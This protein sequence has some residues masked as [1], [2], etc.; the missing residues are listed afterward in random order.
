ML[1]VNILGTGTL[2]NAV[3]ECCMPF[4]KIIDDPDGQDVIWVCHDTPILPNHQPDGDWLMD[5]IAKEIPYSSHGTH[6]LVSSQVPPGF[7][8]RL[9]ARW[10]SRIL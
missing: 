4:H 8:A 7:M 5:E 1:T 2:G 10:P 9:Q 6:I 3:R